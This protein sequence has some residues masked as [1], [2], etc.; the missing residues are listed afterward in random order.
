MIGLRT[1]LSFLALGATCD[2][3][4]SVVGSS[5]P[6]NLRHREVL[7]GDPGGGLLSYYQIV[8]V[9]R[10]PIWKHRLRLTTVRR[11]SWCCFILV[12]YSQCYSVV[13]ETGNDWHLKK[14]FH[15]LLQ[16]FKQGREFV[17]LTAAI[18]MYHL[19]HQR[20]VGVSW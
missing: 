2:L 13:F 12:I 6:E 9:R 20:G 3:R 4:T 5:T 15:K 16:I 18:I 1:T 19:P 17:S 10:R 14:I 11:R 8:E 7:A